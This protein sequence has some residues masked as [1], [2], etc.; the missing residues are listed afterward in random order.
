[1]RIHYSSDDFTRHPSNQ[2]H[3]VIGKTHDTLP[4][5]TVSFSLS[6]SLSPPLSQSLCLNPLLYPPTL[7]SSISHPPCSSLP[8]SPLS[9]LQYISII[10]TCKTRGLHPK[11]MIGCP[12]LLQTDRHTDTLITHRTTVIQTGR[13]TTVRQNESQKGRQTD[14]QSVRQTDRWTHRQTDTQ[15]H[16]TTV[17]KTDSQLDRKTDR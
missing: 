6:L 5:L 11:F 16:R 4:L 17:R 7:P 15:T 13:T 8:P 9:A 12:Q 14:R 2:T 1:M 3:I 10:R